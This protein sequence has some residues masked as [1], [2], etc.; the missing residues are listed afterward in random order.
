MIAQKCGQVISEWFSKMGSSGAW[1]SC[2]FCASCVSLE[3]GHFVLE[4][5]GLDRQ[6]GRKREQEGGGGRSRG[7]P[8]MVMAPPYH[9]SRFY[10]GATATQP[11]PT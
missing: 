1:F 2:F 4:G 10:Q 7:P 8:V 3:C 6:A 11:L 5:G 9:P